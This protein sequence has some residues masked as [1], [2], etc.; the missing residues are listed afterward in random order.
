[1]VE[2]FNHKEF[3]KNHDGDTSKIRTSLKNFDNSTTLDFLSKLNEEKLVDLFDI[4]SADKTIESISIQKSILKKLWFK[5]SNFENVVKKAQTL[6]EFK[7][8]EAHEIATSIHGNSLSLGNLIKPGS[9][10]IL[11]RLSEES[12]FPIFTSNID[13]Y[14]ISKYSVIAQQKIN[15]TSFGKKI[16]VDFTLLNNDA[17]GDFIEFSLQLSENKHIESLTLWSF[18]QIFSNPESN[19]HFNLTEQFGDAIIN[20]LEKKIC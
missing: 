2:L 20:S 7:G 4:F 6:D 12:A 18:I 13:S 8:K 10:D 15:Q 17:Q 14:E 11:E 9:F 3:N 1:M 16:K 5:C 19:Q